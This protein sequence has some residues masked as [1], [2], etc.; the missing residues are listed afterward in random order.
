MNPYKG[1][2]RIS[3][4]AGDMPCPMKLRHNVQPECIACEHA[5]LELLDLDDKVICKAMLSLTALAAPQ[6]G[7]SN[8]GRPKRPAQESIKKPAPV[9]KAGG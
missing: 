9:K 7:G 8:G 1:I 4:T 6:I 5:L 2:I 3:C